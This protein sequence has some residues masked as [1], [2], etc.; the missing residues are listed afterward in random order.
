MLSGGQMIFLN[1]ATTSCA[2][3]DVPSWNFTPGLSLKV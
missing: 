3:N 2:V 1:V